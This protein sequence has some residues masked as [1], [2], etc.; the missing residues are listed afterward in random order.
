MAPFE[1]P[2]AVVAGLKERAEAVLVQAD[3]L[4]V[5]TSAGSLL[6]YA[7]EEGD[8]GPSASLVD[9]KKGVARRAIEQLGYVKDINSLV[10]L[11]DSQVTLYPI[12]DFAP[13]TPLTKAKTVFSFAVHTF[14][15]HEEAARPKSPYSDQSA[16][17]MAVPTVVTYLVVGCQRKMVMYSWK[18][19]DAQ[20]V[21]EAPLPHSARTIAFIDN[22]TVSLSYDLTTHVMFSLDTLTVT[23]LA[24]PPVPSTSASGMGYLGKGLGGY[25]TLG[26][27]AKGRPCAVNIKESEVFLTK[28]NE[29]LFIGPDGKPSRTERIDWPAPPSEI[30]FVK[31]YIF[32]L[33]PAG[34]VP[35]PSA[36]DTAPTFIPSPV[37]QIYSSLSLSPCQTLPFPFDAEPSAS[38][39]LRLLTSSP[40]AKSPLYVIRTPTDRAQA[41][42]EGSTIWRFKMKSW[43]AQL[44]E[45]VEEERYA[46]ALSL[47]ETLDQAVLPDK[48]QRMTLVKSLEAVARFQAGE[49]ASALATFMELNINPARVVA[50]F[51]ESVAGR[52]SRPRSEWIPLF[53]GPTPKA[54]AKASPD[55]PA[56]NAEEKGG[57]GDTDES[58]AEEAAKSILP[59]ASGLM[60]RFKGPLEAI[61]PVAKDPETASIASSTKRVPPPADDTKHA[62]EPLLQYLPD[63]RAKLASALEAF[64]ISASESHMHSAL[65]ESSVENLYALPN[66]PLRSLT[67][68]QL[69]RCAQVVDTALFKTYL[70]VRPGLVSALCRRENWCEVSEMEEMLKERAKFSEL[71]YL[72]NGKKMHSQALDL[73]QKL[74]DDEVGMEDKLRPSISYL[75]RLGPEYLD[76][77]FAHS[78]WVLEQ[79]AD[80]GFEIFTSEEVALPKQQVASFLESINPKLCA[81]FLEFLISERAEVDADYHDRLASLYL[82]MTIQAKKSGAEDWRTDYDKLL[83]YL[84]T[85]EHYRVDRIFSQLPSDD[86]YEAKAVLLGRLGRHAAALELYAYRLHDYTTAEEYC[87][88]I[89]VAGGETDG[90]YLTLLRIYLRPV[91]KT[92][93]DLLPPALS[94]IARHGRR[95]D[96]EA[97]LDLLPPLVRAQDVQAFLLSA[98][99]APVFDTRTTRNAA[100]ARNEQV[101]RKLMYLESNR[102]KVTNTRICPQCHKRIGP[103]VIAVHAPAGEVTHY[104]C[105]EP[106]AMKLKEMRRA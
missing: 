20:D 65:A 15:E 85:T 26:L 55:A 16:R 76:Q 74:S 57:E 100:K 101:A 93:E 66:S 79:D 104:N 43:V 73:L 40:G 27:G 92:N 6:I 88:R 94:L 14:V 46:E 5:G 91:V 45:L 62:I 59:S 49:R 81:R 2:R 32:S 22:H 4:Y 12:P 72:Y 24:L 37:L 51:P 105:R 77:I 30:S 97:A 56:S 106:F 82:K 42:N 47:L 52:L 98:L 25:M 78:R 83:K 70:I 103:S 31:P 68:E 86:L 44:D 102:V 34:T 61:R 36:T 53:G 71:I 10:V 48:E 38:H 60:N 8:D 69:V 67:P 9:T 54:A 90:I 63:R 41:T 75:Q 3:R 1:T 58:A 7:L 17:R 18:D 28:D 11:A 95:L 23:E 64:N 80:L 99:R 39:T 33:L 89:Y 35:A 19:G 96:P 29:G 13:P 84:D 87:K 21:K 50:L